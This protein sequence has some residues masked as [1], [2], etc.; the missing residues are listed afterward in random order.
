MGDKRLEAAVEVPE[1]TAIRIEKQLC[2]ALNK[3]WRPSGMSVETLVSDA[4]R[5]LDQLRNVVMDSRE[6]LEI[7][8]KSGNK[9]YLGGVPY[10]VLMSQIKTILNEQ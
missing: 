4:C 10:D 5:K 7:F 6:K 2:A 3:D 9:E 1:V 8:Y